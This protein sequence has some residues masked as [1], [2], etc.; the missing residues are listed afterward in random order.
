MLTYHIKHTVD[1]IRSVRSVC[2]K[3]AYRC[4]HFL[5]RILNRAISNREANIEP[6][7]IPNN[8]DRA[9]GKA[10]EEP[11]ESENQITKSFNFIIYENILKRI[12]TSCSNL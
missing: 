5:R 1:F 4:V 3:K 7:M 10:S 12:T 2:V 8:T 9:S 6:R 11:L